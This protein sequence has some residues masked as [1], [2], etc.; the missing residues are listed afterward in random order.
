MCSYFWQTPERWFHTFQRQLYGCQRH[1][2]EENSRRRHLIATRRMNTHPCCRGRAL[3]MLATLPPSVVISPLVPVHR[4]RYNLRLH[5]SL[6]SRHGNPSLCSDLP[7]ATPPFFALCLG[8]STSPL[9]PDGV[10]PAR[11]NQALPKHTR[12]ARTEM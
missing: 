8:S 10:P 7:S 2:K 5:T 11:I 9:L 6:R 12:Y 1:K 3:V 4:M